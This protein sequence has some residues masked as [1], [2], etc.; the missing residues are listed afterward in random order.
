MPEKNAKNENQSNKKHAGTYNELEECKTDLKVAQDLNIKHIVSKKEQ[1]KQL[2]IAKK[3]L[4][5]LD[6]IQKIYEKGLRQMM[7]I[8]SHKIRQPITK[9]MGLSLL[10]ENEAENPEELHQIIGYIKASSILLDE[11]TKELT[12]FVHKQEQ[13]KKDYE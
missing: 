2:K 3:E 12:V 10:I 11:F 9:I 7:F 1:E 5:K 13:I 8:I 4:E 6:K